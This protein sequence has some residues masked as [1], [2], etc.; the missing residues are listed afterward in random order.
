MSIET[1]V[2]D[3]AKQLDPRPDISFWTS[4]LSGYTFTPEEADAICGYVR[5]AAHPHI[6]NV[7]PREVK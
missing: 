1:C 4:K 6:V 2:H 7:D 3:S 5:T